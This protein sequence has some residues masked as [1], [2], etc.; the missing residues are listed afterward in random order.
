MTSSLTA[1]IRRSIGR[2]V[3]GSGGRCSWAAVDIR[4]F[5]SSGSILG[6]VWCVWEGGRYTCC[7]FI[8][9][10]VTFRWWYSMNLN[11]FSSWRLNLSLWNSD[12]LLLQTFKNARTCSN[13]AL[14]AVSHSTGMFCWRRESISRN[15]S[16]IDLKNVLRTSPYFSL[17]TFICK[18][19]MKVIELWK[20]NASCNFHDVM[21]RSRYLVIGLFPPVM[22]IIQVL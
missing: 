22:N 19:L 14:L 9:L 2:S 11:T 21:L 13:V 17:R 10:R 8:A 1:F 20:D 5:S 4:L 7:C 18:E 15:L 12:T 16:D 6:L 3:I